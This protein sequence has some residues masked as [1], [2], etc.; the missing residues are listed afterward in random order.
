MPPFEARTS[1]IIS[2]SKSDT[3][4]LKSIF[5]SVLSF[6]VFVDCGVCNDGGRSDSVI[7]C[8]AE[9]ITA[10]SIQF[11]SSRTLLGQWYAH[12]IFIAPALIEVTFFSRKRACF[13]K[14]NFASAGISRRRFRSGGM[15]IVKVDI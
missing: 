10:R 1:T 6:D 2:R 7:A 3:I 12:N 5:S 8:V 15:V 4:L 14:K 9:M 13:C 11:S